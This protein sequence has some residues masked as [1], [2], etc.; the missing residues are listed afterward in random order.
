M[1][2]IITIM[3]WMLLTTSVAIGFLVS[4]MTY[5]IHLAWIWMGLMVAGLIW[6]RKFFH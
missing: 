1:R 3:L 2:D 5:P 6:T 4:L